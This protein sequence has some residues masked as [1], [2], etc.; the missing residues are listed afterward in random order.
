M[1]FGNPTMYDS[2]PGA[3]RINALPQGV[4]GG[5]WNPVY[6]A[7]PGA[8]IPAVQYPGMR[9][10]GLGMAGLGRMP[11]QI[12]GA[13]ATTGKKMGLLIVNAIA[14]AG[15][16]ALFAVSVKSARP[17]LFPAIVFGGVSLATGLYWWAATSNGG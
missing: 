13:E 8:Q 4:P 3:P 1:L 7:A 10:G 14:A 15:V 11:V 2:L 5:P 17:V 12:V 6:R 9:G 16:G